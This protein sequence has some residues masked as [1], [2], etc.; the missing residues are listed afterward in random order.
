[1]KP[2]L[3]LEN[4]PG[5]IMSTHTQRI[6]L[7]NE[8]EIKAIYSLPCF[9]EAERH[10]YFSLNLTEEA[11]LKGL[12]LPSR[13]HFILQLGFFR[14]KHL[15]F[16]FTFQ[17]V[18]DDV[19]YVLSRYFPTE[20]MPK[21]LPSRNSLASNNKRILMLNN[22]SIYSIEVKKQIDA[23]LSQSIRQL[24]NP[25]EMLR[26]LLLYMDH[27]KIVL[28]SYSTLQDLIG[29]AIMTEEKRLNDCVTQHMTRKTTVLID[30]LFTI[31]EDETFYD[32]TLLKHYPKNFNFKMIQ[33]ELVVFPGVSCLNLNC[34][35]KILS[36]MVHLLS[37]IKCRP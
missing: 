6:R 15:L 18:R 8:H 17:A 22:F 14:A 35:N 37:I 33:A 2:T 29:A 13:I 19:K 24:N 16:D 21:T 30:K 1:M 36:T 4:N 3:G 7:L 11:E 32:L 10:H 9:T 12:H 23:K 34:P 25:V 28:P 27:E 31:K 20:K 26:E 5:D